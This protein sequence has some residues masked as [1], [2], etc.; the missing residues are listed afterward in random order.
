MARANVAMDESLRAVVVVSL[1]IVVRV[2][3]VTASKRTVDVALL[4]SAH[5]S[6]VDDFVIDGLLTTLALDFLLS[7]PGA[8]VTTD[9]LGDEWV[10]TAARAFRLPLGQLVRALD[11]ENLIAGANDAGL[12]FE[13]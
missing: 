4:E 8:N 1:D 13:D 7:E 5:F 6:V 2:D 12:R 10:D 3:L 9:R 11:A